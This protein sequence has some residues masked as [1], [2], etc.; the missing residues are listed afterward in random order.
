[1]ETNGKKNSELAT[2]VSA[3]RMVEEIV[4]CKWSLSILQLVRT[5]VNRPG[6]MERSVEGLTAKV[7]TERLKKLVDYGILQREA[8]AE[9]PPRVEYHLTMFGEK[10]MGILDVV[11]Q[12]EKELD[13]ARNLN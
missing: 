7:L 2:Q 10:F 13:N 11:N 1:M 12:L 9:I 4:G 8:Y 3:A 6:A 5:G